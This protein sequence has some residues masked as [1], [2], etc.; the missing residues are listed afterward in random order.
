[1]DGKA[2]IDFAYKF[3][4][5]VCS[6]SLYLLISIYAENLIR[7]C[8]C[9]FVEAGIFPFSQKNRKRNFEWSTRLSQEL[10]E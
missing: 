10:I 5:K 2:I 1:M 9:T 4:S 7:D 8:L 6:L 3:H